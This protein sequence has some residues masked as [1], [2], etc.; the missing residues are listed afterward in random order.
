MKIAKK[1][2]FFRQEVDMSATNDLVDPV[3]EQYLQVL[4]NIVTLSEDE[5]LYNLLMEFKN[6]PIGKPPI[7][8]TFEKERIR[9]KNGGS[10]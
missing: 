5:G 8:S 9:N 4:R 3:H 10:V 1:N 7:T 2:P 6:R